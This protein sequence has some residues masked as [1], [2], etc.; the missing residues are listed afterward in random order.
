MGSETTGET[1]WRQW[2]MQGVPT[3]VV[4]LP[5]LEKPVLAQSHSGTPVQASSQAPVCKKPSLFQGQCPE[6]PDHRG[7]EVRELVW[8]LT[9]GLT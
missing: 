9:L 1:A 3:S 4:F 6:K 5:V 8:Q 7:S 2:S